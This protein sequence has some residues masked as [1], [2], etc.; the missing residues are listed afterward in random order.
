MQK[1]DPFK[2]AGKNFYGIL[3]FILAI[4]L[5]V[6]PVMVKFTL[7]ATPW[8]VILVMVG[9]FIV[10]FSSMFGVKEASLTGAFTGQGK[11]WFIVLLIIVILFSIGSAVGPALLTARTPG[12]SAEMGSGVPV[13]PDEPVFDANG[14]LVSAGSLLAPD[15]GSSVAGGAGGVVSG[16]T[17]QGTAT[18]NFG[19]NL[20][21]TL[22]NPKVVGVLFLFIL[23][24]LTIILINT[25]GTQ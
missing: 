23:G 11:G 10:F 17:R 12:Q 5:S 9:F 18:D 20:I 15:S 21:F 13:S 16:V 3:A 1:V 8:L 14:N 6:S 22:F 19:T 25:G 2:G 7:T 24:S 4:I